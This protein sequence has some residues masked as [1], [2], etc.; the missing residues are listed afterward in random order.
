MKKTIL[1]GLL[2]CGNL[3]NTLNANTQDIVQINQESFDLIK[4][5]LIRVLKENKELKER[6]LDLEDKTKRNADNLVMVTRY[7]KPRIDSIMLAQNNTKKY[8]FNVNTNINTGEI[9]SVKESKKILKILDEKKM[10]RASFI[11]DGNVRDKAGLNH[12][13]IDRIKGGE[14]VTII[15]YQKIG[16][17]LWYELKQGGF[18]HFYNV[19]FIDEKES[20]QENKEAIKGV[21][22]TDKN[23]ENTI[24][25]DFKAPSDGMIEPKPSQAMQKSNIV[26]SKGNQ[27]SGEIQE[28]NANN[29][30]DKGE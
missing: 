27:Y 24:S 9:R 11:R 12:T 30:A 4:S 2:L 15:S 6:I 16:N 3:A 23:E 7:L 21:Q 5:A 13:I 17:N 19:K 22:M 10:D 29:T 26:E 20:T 25:K 28:F 14:N 18:T 8:A 1:L